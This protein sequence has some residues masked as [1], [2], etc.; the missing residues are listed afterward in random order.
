[1]ASVLH[2]MDASLGHDL[3]TRLARGAS[4]THGT[5]RLPLSQQLMPSLVSLSAERAGVFPNKEET[6][7][8]HLSLPLCR[9]RMRCP[10]TREPHRS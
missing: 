1:M 6:L 2:Q 8:Y 5:C 9:V 3:I 4:R 10:R 7:Y